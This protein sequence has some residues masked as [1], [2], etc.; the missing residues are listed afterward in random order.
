VTRS[1]PASRAERRLK[2]AYVYRHF[3]DSGSLPAIFRS[4]AERLS[5]DEDVTVFA[6]AAS[7]AETTAPLRF[8]TVEPLVVGGGRFRY[9]AECASFAF[10]ATRTLRALRPQFDVVHVDGY[11]AT[12]ADI[13]MVHA[14]RPAEIEHY[15][16]SVEPSATFRRRLTP[17]LRPQSGVVISVERRLYRPPYPLCLVV[18]RRV[19]DDLERHY[20]VPGDLIEVMPY[21]I[22]LAAFRSDPGVRAVERSKLSIPEERVVLLFVGD[23]FERKGLDRAIAALARVTQEAELWV[24]GGGA[25]E[26]YRALAGSLGV[27]DRTRF[28]GRV[29]N[30]RLA[31]L[32]SAVDVLVLPSRQDAWGH[33]V[34]EAMAAGRVVLVSEFT[35][36][37]EA[38]QPG[39]TGYLLQGGGSHEEIATL[40]DGP[41]ST[42]ES[43]A[44]I[45]ARAAAAV[46]LYDGEAVAP[47]FR[48]AH[49][50]AVELRRA[51]TAT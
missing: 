31:G 11:S 36:S 41:L 12:E 35:G 27:A 6:S 28:L 20:G 2:V 25:Q 38:I 49:H 8:E 17:L 14:V 30:E 33:T 37:K 1:G 34:I 15:F 7:R 43:R 18:T 39:L 24:A 19:G 21:S 50:R 10:R 47:R 26:R 51:R 46:D 48:A 45:G 22:D 3:N 29:P 16:D 4:R 44:A 42:R 9:A 40:V 5:R 23:D 32:Y 13:V